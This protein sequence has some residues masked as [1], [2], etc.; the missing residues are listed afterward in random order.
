M[1]L[2]SIIKSFGKI[3]NFFKK[4]ESHKKPFEHVEGIL[5]ELWPEDYEDKNISLERKKISRSLADKI[6]IGE[7]KLAIDDYGPFNDYNG[8]FYKKKRNL[9]LVEQIP[10][11]QFQILFGEIYYT[12]VFDRLVHSLGFFII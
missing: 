9:R 3:I 12:S 2:S 1:F 4:R 11:T 8:I 6:I 10:N 7:I 5:K